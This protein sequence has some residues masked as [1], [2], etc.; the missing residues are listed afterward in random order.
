M[1]NLKEAASQDLEMSINKAAEAMLSPT[2]R[3]L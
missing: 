2:Q 1:E 3:L